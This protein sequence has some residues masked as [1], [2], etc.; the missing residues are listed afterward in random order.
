MKLESCSR[1][2]PPL[3]RGGG[4]NA[5]GGDSRHEIVEYVTSIPSVAYGD[6]S[7]RKGRKVLFSRGS[8]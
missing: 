7:P 8:R 3:S 2:S 1:I 6:T 5:A 4:S